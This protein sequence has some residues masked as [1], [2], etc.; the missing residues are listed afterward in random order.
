MR[1]KMPSLT[2]SFLVASSEIDEEL[3]DV[4]VHG[5]VQREQVL[6]ELSI[7]LVMTCDV[8]DAKTGVQTHAALRMLFSPSQTPVGS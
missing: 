3:S 7:M 4:E 8:L 2:F 5:E 6:A 1:W